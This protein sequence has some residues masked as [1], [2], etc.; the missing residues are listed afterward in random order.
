MARIDG[1]GKEAA[2]TADPAPG[3]VSQPTPPS[4]T[5][6]DPIQFV[7]EEPRPVKTYLSAKQLREFKELLLRKRAELAGDVEGL[8]S[9]ALDRKGQGYGDQ[10]SMPIHMA[11]L[12]SD[13]WEQEFTLGLIANEQA[14]VR[15]I[16]DALQRIEDRTFGICVATQQPID[17]ARL[18]AKPWAKYCIEYARLREAGRAP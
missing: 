9:E 13:N 7:E 3:S 15:E 4:P 5:S 6:E 8:T 17:I 2:A 14:V 16:D 11:D 12:G 10:S 18:R 1:G